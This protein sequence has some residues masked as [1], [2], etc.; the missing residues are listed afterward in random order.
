MFSFK[1]NRTF[2]LSSAGAVCPFYL[3]LIYC[4]IRARNKPILVFGSVNNTGRVLHRERIETRIPEETYIVNR[5]LN[6]MNSRIGL[7]A[8]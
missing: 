3:T 2:F 7:M 5:P 6:Y 4:I 8:E 1:G